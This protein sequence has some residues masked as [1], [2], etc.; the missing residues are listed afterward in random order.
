MPNA[1]AS[2]DDFDLDGGNQDNGMNNQS[3]LIT[4]DMINTILGGTEEDQLNVTQRFRKMLSK[5][6]NPPID[7][8]IH[9]GIVPKFVEF[10]QRDSNFTLQ[11]EAAWALTN[12]ASGNSSQTRC[13]I[14]AGALP[15]FVHLL[16][17]QHADVQ[18][19]AVWALGNIAGD[20]PE[21]RDLVLDHGIL[22]PLLQIL[23]E[24]TRLTMTRNAVWCLSNLCRGKNP[25]VEFAKVTFYFFV[26][27]SLT[28][29]Y[30][31][32]RTGSTSSSCSAIQS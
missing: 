3:T 13:V 20:S 10:L 4:Q 24:Q 6:P 26:L 22:P 9:T 2:E 17:S 5:E 15:I 23:S 25:P 31:L 16:S 7:E 28:S 18:E 32:G 11:F 14:E 21:C 19:Q 29:L 30:F 27:I 1:A 12:I 8:V